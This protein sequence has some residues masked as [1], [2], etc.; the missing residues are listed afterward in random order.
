[1]R[2]FMKF[3]GGKDFKVVDSGDHFKSVGS[4]VGL[5]K[6]LLEMNQLCVWVNGAPLKLITLNPH[7]QVDLSKG[8]VLE[9]L[10]L[11]IVNLII[12]YLIRLGRLKN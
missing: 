1:M 9:S 11:V 4:T 12:S 7:P 3:E 2:D 6:S 5:K 8:K 10:K